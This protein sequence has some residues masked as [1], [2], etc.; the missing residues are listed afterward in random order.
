MA[1]AFTDQDKSVGKA[2]RRIARERLGCSLALLSRPQAPASSTGATVHELRKNIKKTRAL[3]R[4][5]RPH[6]DDF[7]VENAALR[8]A[9]RI[10]G[11]LREQAVLIAT[12]DRLTAGTGIAPDRL[13]ALAAALR[14]DQGPPPDAASLLHN[15]A[16]RITEVRTRAGKWPL[17]A[18]G[19]DALQPGIIRSWEAAQK[20][21]RRALRHPDAETLHL[22][23]KRVK[24][25][26]YHARLLERIW[27]Q[28][29]APHI[30][31]A[32]D[33][34]EWLGD[35]RDSTILAEA[36]AALSQDPDG[37]AA[38]VR[39]LAEADAASRLIRARTE[40]AR[41]FAEPGESL[42]RRWREWWQVGAA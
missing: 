28:M 2:L 3:L 11:P 23:R 13:A 38:E 10:L 18:E 17:D 4:L 15:H 24:D 34:G 33:L 21:M 1:F 37:T 32:D 39:A 19:F 40:S 26:W 42:A 5:V 12:F 36:L 29:M 16:D 8:D 31:A 20:A 27:P 35:A 22:W 30:A 6:F 41:L 14:H 25:H 9:A 7:A